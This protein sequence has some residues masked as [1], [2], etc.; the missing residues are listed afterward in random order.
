MDKRLLSK[1]LV[2]GLMSM[3]SMTAYAAEAGGT[4]CG[5]G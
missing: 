2:L 5:W 1:G 4:G 3:G